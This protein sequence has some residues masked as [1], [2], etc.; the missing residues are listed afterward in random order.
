MNDIRGAA[1][2][3]RDI[4]DRLPQVGQGV[5]V[6]IAL[7]VLACLGVVYLLARGRQ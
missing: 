1:D 7:Q 4:A 2:S 6:L 5:G 3:L